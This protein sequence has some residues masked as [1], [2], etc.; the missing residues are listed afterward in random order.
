MNHMH[1][2]FLKTYK[3]TKCHKITNQDNV[4]LLL[5]NIMD[6]ILSI[7]SI[8]YLYYQLISL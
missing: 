3:L 6:L 2:N 4:K 8:I 7:I 1:K 5:E